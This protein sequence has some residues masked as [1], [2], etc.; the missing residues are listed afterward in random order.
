MNPCT[1]NSLESQHTTPFSHNSE[2]AQLG[3]HYDLN[4]VTLNTVLPIGAI[5]TIPFGL[6]RVHVYMWVACQCAERTWIDLSFAY[7]KSVYSKNI[8]LHAA[9]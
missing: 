3:N 2:Y 5:G 7:F 9:S 1:I 6:T 4:S 8:F